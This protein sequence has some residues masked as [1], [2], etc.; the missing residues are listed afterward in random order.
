MKLKKM[1]FKQFNSVLELVRYVEKWGVINNEKIIISDIRS[2]D[3][4]Q[5]LTISKEFNRQTLCMEYG[6]KGIFGNKKTNHLDVF[7]IDCYKVM[8]E[9]ECK[10]EGDLKLYIEEPSTLE[11]VKIKELNVFGCIFDLME[12][13]QES[14]EPIFFEDI[15]VLKNGDISDFTILRISKDEKTIEDN[16]KRKEK[17]K[18]DE[19]YQYYDKTFFNGFVTLKEFLKSVYGYMK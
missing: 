10:Y 14:N 18:I 1:A 13:I 9:E 5:W 2:K 16:K 12:Y 15:V 7:F 11:Q 17:E 8:G 3:K 6:V 4:E 19:A